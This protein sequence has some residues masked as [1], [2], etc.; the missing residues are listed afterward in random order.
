MSQVGGVTAVQFSQVY[1]L[2]MPAVVTDAT[3][4]TVQ[5][6]GNTK[7]NTNIPLDQYMIVNRIMWFITFTKLPAVGANEFLSSWTI[8]P[9]LTEALA[10]TVAAASDPLFVD[11]FTTGIRAGQQATAV[12][13]D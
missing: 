4:G 11:E 1:R 7:F 3:A 8:F 2:I 6:N 10:R 13:I 12:A 5:V 9:Q